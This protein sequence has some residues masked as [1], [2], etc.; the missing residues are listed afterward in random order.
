MADFYIIAYIVGG[1]VMA[2]FMAWMSLDQDEGF[3][4]EEYATCFLLWPVLLP[5][6]VVAVI[7]H[8]KK[9]NG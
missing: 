3:T 2:A 5:V 9:R 8:R 1:M 4:T 7:W 6:G